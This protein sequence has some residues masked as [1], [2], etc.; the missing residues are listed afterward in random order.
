MSSLTTIF[1]FKGV[2][3]IKPSHPNQVTGTLTLSH[4]RQFA[5]PGIPE[6]EFLHIKFL[7]SAGTTELD[8]RLYGEQR[9]ERLDPCTF[10]IEL[11]A[12]EEGALLV[13]F[14]SVDQIV[15][16]EY[17]EFSAE[18]VDLQVTWAQVADSFATTINQWIAFSDGE[19][20]VPAYQPSSY[21]TEKGAGYGGSSANGAPAPYN[22]STYRD[23]KSE[24]RLVLIDEENG[25]EVGEVGGY[26]VHAI[27]VQPGSKEPVEVSL[28][29]DGSGQVTIR[30]ADYLKD[31]LDPTYKNSSI[32]GTAA[33][34]S[35]LIVTTSSYIANAIQYGADTFTKKTKPNETP[36][37]FNPSTHNRVR[38]L[39]TFSSSA[40]KLSAQ[41]VGQVSK[42]AQNLGARI[43]GHTKDR[44]EKGKPANP[45]ILNKSLV[46]FSTIADGIDYASRSLLASGANA[47]TTIVG[48]KYGEEARGVAYGVTGS[49]KN[50]GL[51]YVDAF[52]VS[53]RAVV[54][55]VAK[56]MVIGKVRGG[57]NVVVPGQNEVIDGIPK[58]WGDSPLGGP[59]AGPPSIHTPGDRSP[60]APPSYQSVNGTFSGQGGS[61]P[62]FPPPPGNGGMSPQITGSIYR[63]PSPGNDTTMRSISPRPFDEKAGSDNMHGG[64][65]Y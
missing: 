46:A 61:N 62:Y 14:P 26:Q 63:S 47:A 16:R 65:R 49:V 55:G 60:P 37:M 34:A 39:H 23:E 50:V 20:A 36:L 8:T 12:P 54:R 42:H 1:S 59:H 38:Q 5:Q 10:T 22:P 48:H 17:L 32:V 29:E 15:P 24:G 43:A 35:R 21:A 6:D 44:S 31:A 56:G 64:Y 41:T 25:H 7:S 30:P 57:G 53:R 52:G 58:G 13:I 33:T 3:I 11:R 19:A 45:G 4:E 40:A 27:G 28:P 18:G 51:V 2:Q 9:A